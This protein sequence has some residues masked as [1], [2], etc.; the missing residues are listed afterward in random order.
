MKNKLIGYIFNKENEVVE[1]NT[2]LTEILA[3]KKYKSVVVWVNG[4]KLTTN[5]K[6]SYII[7]ESD[8]IKVMRILGG[9]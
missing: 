6:H 5:K 4:V 2:L 9:G 3:L 1:E 8:E 7:K